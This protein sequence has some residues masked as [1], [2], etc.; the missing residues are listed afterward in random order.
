MNIN[1]VLSTI[2]TNRRGIILLEIRIS[3]YNHSKIKEMSLE[4]YHKYT[5][6]Y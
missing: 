3:V 2:K 1:M 4:Q 6:S 5:V